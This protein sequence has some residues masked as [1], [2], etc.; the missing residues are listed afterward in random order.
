MSFYSTKES[1]ATQD[2]TNDDQAN[3]E[4]NDQE[5]TR[6]RDC[7][8]NDF[9]DYPVTNYGVKKHAFLEDP[10]HV[11]YGPDEP[12]YDDYDELDYNAQYDEH[13]SAE[14]G[15]V[16]THSPNDSARI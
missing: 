4:Y 7:L 5:E 13:P 3:E 1:Q 15:R 14:M 6:H 2:N 9:N 10:N 16:P 12:D 11:M 8:G